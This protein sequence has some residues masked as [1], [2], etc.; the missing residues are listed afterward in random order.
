MLTS[1][2]IFEWNKFFNDINIEIKTQVLST[3]LMGNVR[4]VAA[5]LL[6]KN[7]VCVDQANTYYVAIFRWSV[8]MST[9]SSKFLVVHPTRIERR[10]PQSIRQ[11]K[12]KY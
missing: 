2:A 8:S 4:H 7:R 3:V 11:N 12:S 5:Y 1:A 10:V 9:V 6:K